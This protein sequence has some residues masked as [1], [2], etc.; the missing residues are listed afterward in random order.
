MDDAVGDLESG[1]EADPCQD[2]V[3]KPLGF[4]AVEAERLDEGASGCQDACAQSHERDVV[5]E[6]CDEGAGYEGGGED[7]DEVGEDADA[8]AFCRGALDGLEVKGEVVDVGVDGHVDEADVEAP[9]GNAAL[10]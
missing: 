1:A 6:G 7:G 10:G 9:E 4:G 3:A 5:A 8:G 2:L